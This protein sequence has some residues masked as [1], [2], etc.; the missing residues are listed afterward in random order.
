[1]F[2]KVGATASYLMQMNM[3]SGDATLPFTFL[4]PF[5]ILSPSYKGVYSY[6][7]EFSPLGAN[8][9]V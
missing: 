7:K 2:R 8:Y 6:K 3:L 1:M 5:Y 4:S 9:F